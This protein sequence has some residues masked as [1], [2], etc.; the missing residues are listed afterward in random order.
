MTPTTHLGAHAHAHAP[1]PPPRSA[2]TP[3]NTRVVLAQRP[4][5]RDIADCFRIERMPLRLPKNGQLL[6][7]TEL[8][9][10]DICAASRMLEDAPDGD[11]LALGQVMPCSTVSRVV[12]SRH[13]GFKAGDQVL[14]HTGWQSHQVVDATSIRRKLYPGVAP[15]STA[16]GIYGM[17]GFIA[18]S[19]VREACEPRPGET[20]VVAAASGPIGATAGQLAQMRGARI[21]AVTSSEEKCRHVRETYGFPVALDRH[22]DDFPEQL[23]RA[24]P[25]G[26]DVFLESVHGHCIDTVMPLLN[27]GARMPL[28]GMMEGELWPEPASDRLPAFLNAILLRRLLVRSFT[29]RD[30]TRLHPQFLV[31]PGFMSE[32]GALLRSDHLRWQEE[33]VEGLEQAPLALSR[34]VRGDNLGKLI[35][36]AT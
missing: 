33:Y 5:G 24:C 25:D 6:L 8:V 21:V 2:A 13:A 30:V 22:A 17:Y 32:M 7:K 34:L 31:D 19:A 12:A 23:R 16:L 18:W 35:V 26:V 11:I 28:C 14:A 27:D 36:R 1:A 20:M 4:V 29:H 3:C 15:V 10:I 9:S